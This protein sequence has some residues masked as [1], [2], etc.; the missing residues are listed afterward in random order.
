MQRVHHLPPQSRR[1][2]D[3][4]HSRSHV[5][6]HPVSTE[7]LY[8]SRQNHRPQRHGEAVVRAGG[9]PDTQSQCRRHSTKEV[10]R[11]C[12]VLQKGV[13]GSPQDDSGIQSAV[14]NTLTVTINTITITSITSDL[15]TTAGLPTRHDFISNILISPKYF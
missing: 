6:G 13:R 14:S 5:Q 4:A 7:G 12:L 3:R 10:K 11:R 8:P 1:C 9:V 2:A 15:P